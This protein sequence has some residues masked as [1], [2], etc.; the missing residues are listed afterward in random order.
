MMERVGPNAC[1]NFSTS[2]DSGFYGWLSQKE[3]KT[4]GTKKVSRTCILVVLD[5]ISEIPAVTLCQKA[6]ITSETVPLS[7][8]IE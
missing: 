7:L 6:L 8:A 1:V 3:S 2:K 5:L 4:T